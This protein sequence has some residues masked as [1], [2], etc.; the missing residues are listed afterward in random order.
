MV[1]RTDGT[2]SGT[3]KVCKWL[4]AAILCSTGCG[5]EKTRSAGEA[6][7]EG[8]GS[9]TS[10]DLAVSSVPK[11]QLSLD[12]EA[13]VKGNGGDVVTCF[14]DQDIRNRVRQILFDNRFSPAPVNPF[15]S[16]EIRTAVES[17]QMLDLYEYTL[18]TGIPPKRPSVITIDEP[19]DVAL[20]KLL[21]RLAAKSRFADVLRATL[22]QMP[23]SSWRSA[24]GVVEIDD[25]EHAILLPSKCLLVQIA[26][27][28]GSSVFYDEWLF[29][30]LDEQNRLALVLHEL[31]YKIAKDRNL[32]DSRSARD[33]VGVIMAADAWEQMS[34]WQLHKRL[35]P[36]GA[37]PFQYDVAGRTL[38]VRKVHSE[39]A[40]GLPQEIELSEQVSLNIGGVL[41]EITPLVNQISVNLRPDGSVAALANAK[42]I[43]GD[44]LPE[45]SATKIDFVGDRVHSMRFNGGKF[46]WHGDLFWEVRY[47]EFDGAGNISSVSVGT[48]SSS[49]GIVTAYGPMSVYGLVQF[50][51]GSRVP[52]AANVYCRTGLRTVVGTVYAC[53]EVRFHENGKVASIERLSTSTSFS[54]N[55]RLLLSSGVSL[56]AGEAYVEFF[57]DGNVA[58]YRRR[59][60]V[61][62][63]T[64]GRDLIWNKGSF[65]DV[66]EATF[67]SGNQLETVTLSFLG[68]VIHTDQ[69]AEPGKTVGAVTLEIDADGRIVTPF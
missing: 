5:A 40:A 18:P 28:Q 19:F 46:R 67:R 53:G 44:V 61:G 12:T 4:L 9:A 47:A 63:G 62:D 55:A 2:G 35:L 52:I 17:I 20:P 1:I 65:N 29:S 34:P 15:E 42:Q 37:F 22:D 58:R 54:D 25:S 8:G 59:S 48:Q 57:E 26:V 16:A 41:F 36:L 32:A 33:A 66:V 23:L 24:P 21:D 51:P 60:L 30:R 27:R 39:T 13:D 14:K 56:L 31:A 64:S 49:G 6:L 68:H 43:S 50:Y 45:S 3:A 38:E 69:A 10:E 11:S 7:P